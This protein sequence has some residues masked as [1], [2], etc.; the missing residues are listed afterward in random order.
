MSEN[1]PYQITPPSREKALEKSL[2]VATVKHSTGVKEHDKL[3]TAIKKIIMF[4]YHETKDDKIYQYQ[5]NNQEK[6]WDPMLTVLDASALIEPI[7]DKNKTEAYR[8]ENLVLTPNP[9]VQ[10]NAPVEQPKKQTGNA[11]SRFFTNRNEGKSNDPYQMMVPNIF[12]LLKKIVRLDRFIEYQSYGVKHATWHSLRWMNRYRRF[13]YNRFQFV[14]VPTII[15]KHVQYL[16]K[17]KETEKEYGVILGT[18]NDR[19]MHQT[20]NDMNF[21]QPNPQQ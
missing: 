5:E 15:R 19:I 11:I 8:L 16:E 13:H 2:A 14:V 20:R 17:I 12:E 18:A 21:N 1:N 7:I 3:K 6:F 10:S 4:G 9:L